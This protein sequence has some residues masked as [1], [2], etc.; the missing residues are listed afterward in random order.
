[1]G[2]TKM[3]PSDDMTN[4][5]DKKRLSQN[6]DIGDQRSSQFCELSIMYGRKLSS[7]GFGQ[8]PL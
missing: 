6:F 5:V 2:Y 7:A 3:T 4:L 8:E 1:M